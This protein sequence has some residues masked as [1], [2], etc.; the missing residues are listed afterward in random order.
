MYI[1]FLGVRLNPFLDSEVSP[2]AAGIA[3]RKQ[4]PADSGA[5]DEGVQGLEG[6]G[7]GRGAMR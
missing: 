1:A 2:L 5:G 6:S 4:R 7:G 3:P